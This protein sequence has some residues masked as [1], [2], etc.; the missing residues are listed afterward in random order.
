MSNLIIRPAL[1]EDWEKI[2][3]L[4][5]HGMAQGDVRRYEQLLHERR[6]VLLQKPGFML[7][8]V[9]VGVIQGHIVVVGRVEHCTLYYGHTTVRAARILDVVTHPEARRHGH[10]SAIIREL[11]TMLAEQRQHIALLRDPQT[12]YTRY[13][14][15]P[16]WPAYHFQFDGRH[17]RSSLSRAIRPAVVADLPMIADLYHRHWE[18]RITVQ[19]S[20][21]WWVWRWQNR[22]RPFVI[23]TPNNEIEGYLWPPEIETEAP[24]V[25]VD[26]YEAALTLV[27]SAA[28]EVPHQPIT[29]PLPPDDALIAYAELF[30]PVTLSAVYEPKSGWMAR[31]INA[32]ALVHTVLPEIVRMAQLVNPSF[33]ASQLVLDVQSDVVQVGLRSRPH[34]QMAIAH[35]D[36]L[37]VM[38]GSLRPVMLAVRLALTF[39]QVHLLEMLFPPRMGAFAPGDW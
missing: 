33:D 29:W 24:E 8:N 15:N 10:A 27:Q 14:F 20:P 19:R 16:V 6:V 35:Q 22:V 32:A 17:L 26:T 23:V 34:L 5:A 38:F 13:G 36:F 39:E 37:R 30:A 12:F 2:C 7:D 4:I 28:H 25:L 9:R 11:L 1:L 21:S 3:S 18:R 31:L